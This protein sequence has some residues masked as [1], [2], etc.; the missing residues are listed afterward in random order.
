MAKL[1]LNW[2]IYSVSMDPGILQCLT[3]RNNRNSVYVT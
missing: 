3:D 2:T 1:S